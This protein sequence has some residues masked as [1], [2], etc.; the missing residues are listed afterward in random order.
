VKPRF[1]FE[2]ALSISATTARYRSHRFKSSNGRGALLRCSSRRS[3][4]LKPA[5]FPVG[6]PESRAAARTLVQRRLSQQKRCQFVHS[7]RG[8]WRGEGPEPFDVPRAH[9]WTEGR[10]GTLCRVVY[11]PHVWIGPEE[12]PPMCQGCGTPYRKAREFRNYPLVEY[13]ADCTDKHIP[14]FS[15]SA[16][17]CSLPQASAS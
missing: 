5:N 17:Y 4:S 11:I 15:S 10:D 3:D 16:Q 13:R 1:Y 2:S 7:V 9:P 6:S 8:P 12:T 14:D